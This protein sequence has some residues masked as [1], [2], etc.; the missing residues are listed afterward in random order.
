MNPYYGAPAF[1]VTGGGQSTS[2][3]T[4]LLNASGDGL[5]SLDITGYDGNLAVGGCPV[6][7]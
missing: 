3:A 6:R 2:G 5:P 1:R 4:A 7:C